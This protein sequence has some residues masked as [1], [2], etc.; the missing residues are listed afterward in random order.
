MRLQHQLS[1]GHRCS[2]LGIF[3]RVAAELHL[4]CAAPPHALPAVQH[5]LRVSE[6]DTASGSGLAHTS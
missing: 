2:Q 3:C 4:L 5:Q 6:S 1:T